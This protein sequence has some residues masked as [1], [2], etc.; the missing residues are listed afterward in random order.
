M[1]AFKDAHGGPLRNL[2]LDRRR[3]RGGQARLRRPQV[4]GPDRAPAVRPRA[5]DERRLLAARGLHGPRR[6]RERAGRHAPGQRHLVADPDHA[7]RHP[8][9]RRAARARRDHRP[10]RPRGRAQRHA[11]RHRPLAARQARRGASP[12]SAPTTRRTRP[13]ATC[14]TMPAASISAARCRAS[15]RRCTTTSSICATRRRSC[16]TA[17]GSW[18]GAA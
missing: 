15:R 14:T 10:A 11:D 2:Y 7:R 1:G 17:S 9:L 12:C 5:A 16:A 8:G 3:R 13:C 6:L 18:A 4:L